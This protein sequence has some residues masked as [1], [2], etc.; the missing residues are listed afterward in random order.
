MRPN[1]SNVNFR[2]TKENQNSG[3]RKMI[4]KR[5]GRLLNRSMSSLSMERR[6]LREWSTS[7]T[8]L[9]LLLISVD[10]TAPCM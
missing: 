8:L 2:E 4:S 1:F 6:T 3:R 9:V 5:H 10:L 7:T